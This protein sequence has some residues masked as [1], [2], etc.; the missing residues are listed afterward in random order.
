METIDK[1]MKEIIAE[2]CMDKPYGCTEFP[3]KHHATFNPAPPPY[4]EEEKN[5]HADIE[6]RIYSRRYYTTRKKQQ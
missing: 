6:R 3:K 1:I 4:P 2:P 5:K